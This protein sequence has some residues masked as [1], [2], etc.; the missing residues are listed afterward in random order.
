MNKLCFYD[1]YEA[2]NY[3]FSNND[4]FKNKNDNADRPNYPFTPC[5]VSYVLNN[6]L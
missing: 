4:H 5:S 1:K 2:F 6:H 3:D